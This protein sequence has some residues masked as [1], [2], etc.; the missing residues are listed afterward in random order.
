ML[1]PPPGGLIP[2]NPDG[3]LISSDPPMGLLSGAPRRRL[4]TG[5][6]A[7]QPPGDPPGPLQ[8]GDPAAGL[9]PGDPP[10]KPTEGP[11]ASLVPAGPSGSQAAAPPAPRSLPPGMLAALTARCPG[12]R[13]D[14]VLHHGGKSVLAVGYVG[15]QPVV[16]KMSGG[17]DPLWR[18]RQRHEIAVYMIFAKHPP[19]VRVPRLVCTDGESIVVMER[20]EG[21][22]LDIGRYPRRLLTEQEIQAT[23]GLVR[24][25]HDWR[26]LPGGFQP[27]FGYRDRIARYHTAGYFGDGDW[28][29]LERLLGRCGQPDQL[30]HG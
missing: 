20:L 19:P 25:L 18:L 22:P 23:T 10:G 27:V 5:D 12:L 21:T 16:I 28:R 15:E 26:P 8:P 7:G 30:N 6:Q 3:P 29:A 1:I 2:S 11:P 17:A 4:R 14:R 13:V 9:L 24:T